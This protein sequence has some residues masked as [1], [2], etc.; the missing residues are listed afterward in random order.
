M[1]VKILTS[2]NAIWYRG[3][4]GRTIEVS[5]H[6]SVSPSGSIVYT[7]LVDKCDEDVQDV[8]KMYDAKGNSFFKGMWWVYADD[9]EVIKEEAIV[10]KKD[11]KV[12]DVVCFIGDRYV[13]DAPIITVTAVNKSY[14]TDTTTIDGVYFNKVSGYYVSI[15]GISV[16]TVVRK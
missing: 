12:G 9:C 15:S 14:L 2:N 7:V 3:F 6:T 5:P 4:I 13:K 16:D 10:E 1:K 8:L 11:I